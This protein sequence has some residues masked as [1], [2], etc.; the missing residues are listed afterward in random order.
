MLEF[1]GQADDVDG[2]EGTFLDA[3]AAAHAELFGDYR[4]S[5]R[6]DHNGLVPG[7]H[8]GTVEDALGTALLCMAPVFVDDRDSHGDQKCYWGIEVRRM[9]QAMNQNAKVMKPW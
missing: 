8:A 2:I 7:P 4:F 1:L 3:D 5:L 6:T 9:V